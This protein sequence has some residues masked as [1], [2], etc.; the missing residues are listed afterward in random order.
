MS[1]IFCEIMKGKIPCYK[2]YEDEHTLAFL[3]IGQEGFGH[4]L[5]ISK[6]HSESFI[7]SNLEELTYCIQTAKKISKHYIQNCGFSGVNILINNGESAGQSVMH[8]HIHIIP[9]KNGDNILNW[10]IPKDETSLEEVIKMLE[11]KE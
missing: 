10:K 5:V 4:T 6:S 7:N 1:C 2:I 11:V 8:F 9:R 3:D